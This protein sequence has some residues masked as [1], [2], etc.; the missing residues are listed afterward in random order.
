M[1]KLRVG[2]VGVG[3]LGQHHVKH[4]AH[5]PDAQLMGVF[6]TDLEQAAD[7]AERNG[8]R[9]YHSINEMAAD[10]Q[11]ITIAVPTPAHFDV[12]VEMRPIL[13]MKMPMR[14]RRA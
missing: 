12:A 5:I 8:T 6:D 13:S 2:V 14:F 1:K 9:V 10:C 7:I 3:H 11:A 4:L